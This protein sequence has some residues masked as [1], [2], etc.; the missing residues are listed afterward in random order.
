MLRCG[1]YPNFL[2][3]AI[4]ILTGRVLMILITAATIDE[5]HPLNDILSSTEEAEVFITGIG[6]VVTAASLS[7]Y[8]ALHGP[9]IKTVWNIGV[10]G[11]YTGSRVNMLDICLAQQ[12]VLGDF[13]I[14]LNNEIMDFDSEIIKHN[15]TYFF[16]GSHFNQFK[17][18]LS[19]QGITF[20][21]VNFV[22]VNCCTGTLKRG[23]FLRKKYEAGCENMEGAAIAMV[24]QNADIPCVELRCVSNMVED[25]DKS[26]WHLSEAIKKV[27]DATRILL[28]TG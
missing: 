8:L 22:T 27:C 3:R 17:K 26:K 20:K 25:R 18:N 16:R 12:E 28:Q 14:C 2:D 4:Q 5:V 19:G 1:K 21:T 9:K 6:P 23:E 7:S 10:A 15:Q 13:G 11:A 24:C